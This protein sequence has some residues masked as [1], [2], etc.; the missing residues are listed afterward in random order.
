MDNPIIQT[1]LVEVLQKF[2]ERFDKLDA[3]FDKIDA[4]FDKIDERFIKVDERLNKL[5]VGQARIEEKLEAQEKIVTEL[6][7]SQKN[8]IWALIV[9]AFTAVVS[10]MAGLGKFIFFPNP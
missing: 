7:N 8:Q 1:D 4:R 2:D 9:L 6:K 3:R 5:D 10:L